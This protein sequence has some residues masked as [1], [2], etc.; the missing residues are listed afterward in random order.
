MIFSQSLKTKTLKNQNGFTLLELLVALGIFAVLAAM[1][2]SGLNSV[3]TAR[4]VTNQHA[5]R[6]S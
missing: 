1:A 5:D 4:Q 3:M 6:L 2:Y